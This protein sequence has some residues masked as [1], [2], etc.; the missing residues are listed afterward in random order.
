MLVA[1]DKEIQRLREK[2]IGG[3]QKQVNFNNSGIESDDDIISQV[4]LSN[5]EDNSS[6]EDANDKRKRKDADIDGGMNR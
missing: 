6:D 2:T 5:G 3:R 1:K 4:Y